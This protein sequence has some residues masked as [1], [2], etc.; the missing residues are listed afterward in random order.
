MKG[1]TNGWNYFWSGKWQPGLGNQYAGFGSGQS[2]VVP[3]ESL[4]WPRGWGVDG[5]IKGIL[6]Q[7]IYVP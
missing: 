4:Q 1:G 7:R 6:G 5:Y 2:F 3:R